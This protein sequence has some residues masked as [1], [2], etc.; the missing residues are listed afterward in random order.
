MEI[1]KIFLLLLTK[2]IPL[3]KKI[4]LWGARIEKKREQS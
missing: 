4:T 3:R 2:L 1:M